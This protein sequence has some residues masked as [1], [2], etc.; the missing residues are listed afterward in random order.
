[1][2]KDGF[3]LVFNQDKLQAKLLSELQLPTDAF[4]IN[5]AS[6]NKLFKQASTVGQRIY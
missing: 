4:V 1:M 3:I 5:S 2:L 6:H